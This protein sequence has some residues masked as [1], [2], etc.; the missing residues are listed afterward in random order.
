MSIEVEKTHFLTVGDKNIT[1]SQLPD[2]IKDQVKVFDEIRQ[3]V[4][5]KSYELSVYQLAAEQ[6]KNQL[7]Q[8]L[9]QYLKAQ[10]ENEK[11]QNETKAEKSKPKS[12]K[13]EPDA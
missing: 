7:E 13:K 5:N 10:E 3:D 1:V 2:Q 12:K 9:G 4:M 6:K 11:K 8:L